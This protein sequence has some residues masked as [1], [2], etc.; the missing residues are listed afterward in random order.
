MDITNK[1][2]IEI[3]GAKYVISTTEDPRY[4]RELAVEIEE[5]V[6]NFMETNPS[7]ARADA[8]MIILLG[9][10]DLYKKSEENTDN[11][12]SQLTQYLE[13]AARARIEADEYKRE[14]EKLKREINLL[15]QTVGKDMPG[16]D[17]IKK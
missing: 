7:A 4:V 10:V 15:R 3:Y 9:Y 6:K 5:K 14:I 8:Y 1:V 12:R 2:R 11:I 16:A 17:K 13:D